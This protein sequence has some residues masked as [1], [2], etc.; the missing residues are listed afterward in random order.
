MKRKK[1]NVHEKQW[2][3]AKL[4]LLQISI[5]ILNTVLFAVTWYLYYKGKMWGTTFYRKGDYVLFLL[6]MC[7][8]GAMAKLYGGIALRTSRITELIYSQIVSIIITNAMM[9]IIILLLTRRPKSI[10]PLL[11]VT[12]IECFVSTAWSYAANHL[13]NKIFKPANILLVYDNEDAY[14]NAKEIIE[15][16]AWRFKLSGELRLSV[17]NDGLNSDNENLAKF[18]DT[19]KKVGADSVMLCGLVSSKRNDLI[20]YCAEN[21]IKAF[22][23]PNI[24][25]FMISNAQVVQ[26]ANLPVMIC[27]R[28]TQGLVYMTVK[29]VM[30]IIIALIGLILTSP[31][32]LIT[33][34]A[35]KAYDGGPVLYKQVRLTKNGR[36]FKILKFRSMKVD[37]EK[38]GVARLSSQNDDRITPIGKL[39]RACRVDELPQLFNILKGDLTCV[40]PRPERP[41][42]A[43][44]YVKEMP[45]F[46]LR[47]QVKAGLTGYAQVYGKYNTEPYDKLQ[48]DLMYVSKM[49]IV[50][51]LKIILATIKI[52]FMPEST[53]GIAQGQTTASGSCSE[54]KSNG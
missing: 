32:L 48:M 18:S 2:K 36:E 16:L 28:A 6:Y 5:V 3:N 54:V 12:V 1:N 24:G 17:R 26:M 19:Y 51:D 21:D 52:L 37:A 9:Y 14:K 44:Q 38:D 13:C 39:I 8:F 15:K 53:E 25:D 27:E 4:F 49:G 50:T 29:R 10:L 43:A 20:K 30:D 33:A 34:I 7:L 45:E 23:R 42:I 22:V 35:I 41:E 40:G 11:L 46:S 31:F 47:L